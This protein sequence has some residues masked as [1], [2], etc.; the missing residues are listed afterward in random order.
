M[1]K[2]KDKFLNCKEFKKIYESGG[3]KM[4][5][6]LN[7]VFILADDLGWSDLNCYGS[8]VYQTPNIDQ[9][10]EEGMKFTN[11]Y[12]ACTVC[13]PTRAS[14]MTGKYPARLNLTNWISGHNFLDTK[15]RE[16]EWTQYLSLKETTIAARLK[17]E[18]YK[19]AHIGKWHL[20]NKQ[21]F[22]EKHGFDIN[23]AGCDWGTPA[24][25]YFSPWQIPTLE[26]E[27]KGKYLTDHLTDSA[28]DFIKN[29]KK[30]NFFLYL[31]F[32][33]V[34][35]PLEAKREQE[36]KFGKIIGYIP[37]SDE[38]QKPRKE[39]LEKY[40]DKIDPEKKQINATY[41]AMIYNMD[42]C[43]GKII[44]TLEKQGIM[45][46]TVIIFTS[47]NGGLSHK[48]G[49]HINIT[50]NFPLRAGKGS[51]YE[52]GLRV[53]LIIKWPGLTEAKSLCDEPV[54]TIDFL[55]TILAD[56]TDEKESW[57][58]ID[59]KNIKPLLEGSKENFARK[60]LYW[61]YPH[62]HP[63]SMAPH[64]VIRCGYWKLI[65]YYEDDKLELYNLKEDI[66]EH[67]NLAEEKTEK[68][69]DL[70]QALNDWLNEVEAQKP[71]ARQ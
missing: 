30:E 39:I 61:H 44:K 9:L 38:H 12:A 3:K 48:F 62:Y 17:K 45:D 4:S 56:F 33:A 11:S 63:G 66:G 27:I 5:N 13:S 6:Q 52:G 70:L 50:D 54:S 69:N 42:E 65:C 41:A 20:G 31:S 18:G 34:H 64:S 43:V 51:A 25:G 26:D 7:F 15:L 32:Y 36:E 24:E 10:A 35:I 47:D 19:T 57:K 16:P 67:N 71:I 29:N 59:G 2:L 60:S 53:P 37:E 49:E 46:N 55:P 58:N 28:I 22:P 23:I 21:Y 1:L 8:E 14:I 68:T 40:K